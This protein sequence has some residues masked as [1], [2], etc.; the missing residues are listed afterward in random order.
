MPIG[1]LLDDSPKSSKEQTPQMAIG[2]LLDDSPKSS[3]EQTPQLA[4]RSLLDDSPKSSKEQTPQLAIG[5]LL[6]DSPK[7]SKEQTPQMAIGSLLHD[8]PKSSKEQTPQ[9]PIGSLLDDSPQSSKEQ[10][11]QMAI[12]SLLDDSPKRS[13]EQT[14]QMAIGSL[15]DDSPKSSKE[16]TPQMAIGS[17]LDDSPKSSKEQTP[18]L[19]IGSLLDDG[20]K[21]SKEQT[22]QM[23][24]GSLLDDSPKSSKEQ[25]PQMPIGS[26]L[27]DSP[28][29]SKE[30]TPQMTIGSLLDDSLKSSPKS[31]KEQTPLMVIGL[32]VS[33]PDPSDL[34]ASKELVE[35]SDTEKPFLEE[36]SH[37]SEK[38]D[39][40]ELQTFE[41]SP[42]FEVI[43]E[44]SS[45]QG[46]VYED[47][48]IEYIGDINGAVAVDD[49]PIKLSEMKRQRSDLS[50]TA[51]ISSTPEAESYFRRK[52]ALESKRTDLE[53]EVDDLSSQTDTLVVVPVEEEEDEDEKTLVSTADVTEISDLEVK[54]VLEI[55][56]LNEFPNELETALFE[57]DDISGPGIEH[58]SSFEALYDAA[59]L[60]TVPSNIPLEEIGIGD[61]FQG[62]FNLPDIRS[63]FENLYTAGAEPV[64]SE[65]PGKVY[66]AWTEQRWSECEMS[67][68]K[69]DNDEVI[70]CLSS[71]CSSDQYEDPHW[72]RI[73]SPVSTSSSQPDTPSQG[74]LT[75]D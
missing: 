51:M 63:S 50:E 49:I 38:V 17:L 40:P 33:L 31:S 68:A 69:S 72:F 67:P 74:S 1:S 47:H 13:K 20:P 71:S 37:V 75:K 21:S 7:S 55:A 62:T 34:P 6:D 52:A 61:H 27:D 10:T 39:E 41:S 64:I 30:Q 8:T 29:G 45:V 16:Q 56:P 12:G 14:P 28:K 22:P 44:S 57:Q 11:P 53:I 58:S 54:P 59:Q 9:M 5:S 35:L 15:L 42:E 18:Q 26:L 73:K 4:I 60:E 23:A 24:I 43:S 3:K 48:T 2:S 46:E 70:K 19:A 25:P 32:P 65:P 36:I 66:H